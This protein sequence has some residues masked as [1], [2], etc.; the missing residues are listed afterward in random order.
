MYGLHVEVKITASNNSF[1][2]SAWF[3]IRI[4]LGIDKTCMA[5]SILLV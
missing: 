5:I 4:L 3:G 1:F 2:F